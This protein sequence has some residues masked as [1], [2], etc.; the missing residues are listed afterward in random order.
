MSNI[1]ASRTAYMD[2]QKQYPFEIVA[3]CVLPNH[4]HAIWTLPPDDADYSLRLRLIK[5]KFSA[6]FPHAE[7]LSASKQRQHER[8]IWQ[9]RFYE[10]TVRDETDLQRCADYPF[11]SRQTWIMRQCPRLGIFVVSPLRSG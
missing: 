7:N 1:S 11:Q 2:V 9:R 6:H 5:T 3:V 8:G 4:I 10:H